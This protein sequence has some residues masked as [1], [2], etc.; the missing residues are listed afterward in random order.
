MKKLVIGILAH[1]DAGK[2]TL[3]EGLLYLTGRIKTLGRV[4]RRDT[5]LDNHE[6]ERQRGITIFSKQA[7]VETSQCSLTLLDT[8]GHA[9]FAAEAERAVQVLDYAVVVISGTDGVQAHTET[10][11]R[12]LER[13]NVPAFIFVTKMDVSS[14]TREDIM[15][16]LRSRFGGGCTDFTQPD[17]EDIA[18]CSEEALESFAACGRLTDGEIAELVK[19]RALFPCWFGSGLKLDGVDALIDGIDRYT[20]EPERSAEFGA[21]VYKISRDE[22]GGRLAFM[23]ITGGVLRV[24]DA[25]RYQGRD[26]EELEEKVNQ[27]R[28]YSGQKYDAAEAVYPGQVCAA[29]GLSQ[30]YAGQGLGCEA[31]AA[32]P[33]LEP[34]LTYRVL[35]PQGCDPMLMLPK[36]RQLEEE[37]PMLRVVWN[38]RLREIYVQLMGAV[39]TE[40]LKSLIKERFDVDVTVDAG[41]I[42]YRE[43]IAAPVEGVGH[44]EPLRHYAEVH[45]LLE[46]LPRGSGIELGA[47]CPEDV[48]DRSWQRLILTHL[49]EKRHL[50]V[51]TGSPV[52]DI[53][54]TLIAGRAHPKHTEGGDF[55]E[56]VYRAVRQG[57]MQ[58]E[59]LLL[60]PYYSFSLEV[61][62]TE[63]GRAINDIRAMGGAFSS[64][65]GEGGF[66]ELTGRAPV[67]AM[68]EYA[69]SVAAYTHGRGHFACRPD[70]YEV[71]RDPAPI[72]EAAAYDPQADL[73]NTPDSVFCAH[74]AGFNVKWD[75]VRDYMHLDTGFGRDEAPPEAPILRSRSLDIDEKELEAIMDREFGPIRRPMYSS[76]QYNSAAPAPEIKS[77]KEY[78]FVDGYNVIFAWKELAG[79]AQD[80]MDLARRTLADILANY[81]GYTSCELVLVFDAYRIPGGEG[82]REDYHGIMIAYTK[83]GETGDQYIEKLADEIGKNYSVRVVTSD[84]LIQ[85]SAFRSGVL[86]TS[87]REFESEV[88]WVLSRID[89]AIARM[90]EASRGEKIGDRVDLGGKQ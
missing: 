18:M 84:N 51:L 69:A 80:N 74:G 14:R 66:S 42:M 81:R 15:A 60:E 13:Y 90:G 28:I 2:T 27:L 35:L 50:G 8:P 6:L 46:P 37:D 53:K 57:L 67:A 16:E 4:D 85:L 73:E 61:P 44:F 63:L 20:A 87:A 31:E 10:L 1:V 41:R 7:I 48:L 71:C 30:A 24:K 77:K 82:S 59:S 11:W 26:G 29:S 68:R 32:V 3:S 56:A 58:A 39:Q 52:T 88:S 17:F 43:T 64:R 47:D 55:R 45:L 75:K 86:R 36:L 76:R 9:D 54:I 5:F 49:A 70:G 34:V 23:K 40:I 62:P 21:R 33:V 19:K 89:E 12:L 22:R 79:I 38:S 83:Q 78:I 25:V 65:E 72:I